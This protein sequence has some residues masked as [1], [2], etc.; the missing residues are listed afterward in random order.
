MQP[1]K[2]LTYS[3]VKSFHAGLH[4][5][6]LTASEG[7]E[8]LTLKLNTTSVNVRTSRHK[9]VSLSSRSCFHKL[10]CVTE[11]QAEAH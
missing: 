6:S 8:V 3:C 7:V 10:F 5:C 1:A 11:Q 9:V 2:L 4:V